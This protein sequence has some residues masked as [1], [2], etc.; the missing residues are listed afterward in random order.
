M[1]EVCDEYA[2]ALARRALLEAGGDQAWQVVL[3]SAA[4]IN[5]QGG[6]G[7]EFLR[8]ISVLLYAFATT[9]TVVNETWRKRSAPAQFIQ[10][11]LWKEDI[12]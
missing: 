5:R 3:E 9:V 8:R 10:L 7:A 6:D 12:P 11:S 2:V 1:D 4:Q